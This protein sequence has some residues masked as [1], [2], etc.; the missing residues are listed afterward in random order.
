LKANYWWGFGI[1]SITLCWKSMT[2]YS[3]VG[4]SLIS[5]VLALAHAELITAFTKFKFTTFLTT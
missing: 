5:G 4:V 1:D 3:R 2:G